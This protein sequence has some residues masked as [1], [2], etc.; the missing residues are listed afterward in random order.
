MDNG[1]LENDVV[2]DETIAEDAELSEEVTVDE[3]AEVSEE[4]TTDEAAPSLA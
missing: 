2:V 3:D 4:E 1:I